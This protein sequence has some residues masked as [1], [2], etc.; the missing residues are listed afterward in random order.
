MITLSSFFSGCG[1]LDLGFEK[2]GFKVVWSNEFDSSI[3]ETY[4]ANHK[5]TQLCK[6]DLRNIPIAEIPNCDGF[7]GGP[8][9]Q[10]WSEGGKQKGLDDERGK[11]FLTYV[12]IIKKKHPK[13]FVIENVKG[14][15]S[16]VHYPTFVSFLRILEDAGYIIHYKLMNAADY[17]IPQDRFRVFVVGFAK[18]LNIDYQFPKELD[19][20]KITLRQAISDISVAPRI[21]NSSSLVT[22]NEYKANHDVYDGPFDAKYMARNRVRSWNEVSFTIPAQAR[23]CPLHPQAPTMS[24][25]SPNQRIF[26]K[27]KEHLYRRLSVR[28]CARIQSFPDNFIFYYNKILDGYKMIGNAV[29]PRLAYFLAISIKNALNKSIGNQCDN[30]ALVGYYKNEKQLMRTLETGVYYV[31]TGFR[32]GAFNMPL[33]LPYP[34][35]LVLHNKN[36]KYIFDLSQEEPKFYSKSDL[37]SLGFESNGDCYIGFHIKKEHEISKECLNRIKIKKGRDGCIPYLISI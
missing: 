14:I 30:Y 11:L 22:P 24:Y 17:R 25:V 35:Y 12:S 8:P 23:N 5:E 7:I 1:G 37:L 26:V 4:K 29:P 18:E 31:R 21:Y 32:H 2:A 33:G 20:P 34:K 36:A 10:S 9:C 27:G 15:I 13:F 16:D 19:E 6:Q 28:E 3:H